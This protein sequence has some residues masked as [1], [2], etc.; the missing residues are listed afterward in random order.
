MEVTV[1]LSEPHKGWCR[2]SLTSACYTGQVMAGL[3]SHLETSSR[4]FAQHRALPQESYVPA[5]AKQGHRA[6]WHLQGGLEKF[7]LGDGE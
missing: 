4:P 2:L 1:C 3:P 5:R 7:G 6:P